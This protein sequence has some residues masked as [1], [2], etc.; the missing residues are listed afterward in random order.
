MVRKVR[1]GKGGRRREGK[2]R[3]AQDRLRGEEGKK[4][5]ERRGQDTYHSLGDVN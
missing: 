3:G 4:A 5:K 2:K 1:G